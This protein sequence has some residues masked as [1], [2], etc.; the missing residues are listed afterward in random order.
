MTGG[1]GDY[2]AVVVGSGYGGSIAACRLAAAGVDVCLIERGRRWA[3]GDFPTNVV[4][5]LSAVRVESRNWRIA[6]GKK[7]ALF[8]IHEQGDS[9]AVVACG[10]GGGSLINAGVIAPTPARVKKDPRWPS[11]WNKDW[12]ACEASATSALSAQSIPT[13]FYNARIMREL[14][15]EAL[16]DCVE[17]PVKLS[18]DFG[19]GRGGGGGCLG[20]GNCLSGCPYDAKNSTD[21]NYLASAIENGCKVRTGCR[22]QYV[23]QNPDFDRLGGRGMRG[24]RWWICFD[25]L[26]YVCADF[27]VLSGIKLILFLD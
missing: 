20:C 10:L 22:A 12:D 2:D 11:E 19:G 7:D 24:R 17:S 5:L 14:A 21:K 16:E 27:V 13:E 6:L 1:G 26:D 15:R 25:D 9:L 4:G 18:I 8:Q 23:V 3:A